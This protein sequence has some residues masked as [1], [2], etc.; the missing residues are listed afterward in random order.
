MPGAGWW[1]CAGR[2]VRHP[3]QGQRRSVQLDSQLMNCFLCVLELS[4]WVEKFN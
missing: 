1:V 4:M 3:G 2:C